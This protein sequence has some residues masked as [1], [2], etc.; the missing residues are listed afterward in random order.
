VRE[1]ERE[2]ARAHTHA[3]VNTQPHRHTCIICRRLSVLSHD[4][5]LACTPLTAAAQE[6]TH[7]PTVCPDCYARGG[8]GMSRERDVYVRAYS[9]QLMIECMRALFAQAHIIHL[10]FSPCS[11]TSLARTLRRQKITAPVV[12]GSACPRKHLLSCAPPSIISTSH[13]PRKGRK[14]SKIGTSI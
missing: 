2:R 5:P 9:N 1:R 11:L 4:I 7:S 14:M 8:E 13:G 3:C 12:N 6:M 10:I